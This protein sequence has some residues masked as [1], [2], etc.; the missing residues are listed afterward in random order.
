MLALQNKYNK[1]SSE[2]IAQNL[3]IKAKPHETFPIE[4]KALEGEKQPE[5]E[6]ARLYHNLLPATQFLINKLKYFEI[7]NEIYSV[8]I[9]SRKNS[10][11]VRNV[12]F[13]SLFTINFFLR[14]LTPF[15][16]K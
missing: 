3:Q 10:N 14:N 8:S 13:N 6:L 12:Y 5:N 2:E 7:N 15:S 9:Q 4:L 1:L 16:L 11:K